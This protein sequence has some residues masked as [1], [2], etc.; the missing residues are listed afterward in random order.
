M[1]DAHEI[2]ERDLHAYVDGELAPAEVARVEAWLT[3]NPC[4]AAR[5]TAYRDQLQ[6]M[7]EA[8]DPVLSEAVP[9]RLRQAARPG[10]GD[11]MRVLVRLAAALALL[12]V[13]FGAGWLGRDA[14][15]GRGQP[16]VDLA[17][18]SL[19]AHRVYVVE[20]RH[21]VEVAANEEQHLVAWL[22]KRIGAPVRAPD[23]RQVG[24]SLVGGRLL[25]AAG[26]PAAQL[27]YETARGERVTIY[28]RA[29]G[30]DEETAFRYD[31]SGDLS[32]FYWLEK[33]LAYAIVAELPREDLLRVA[34]V[35]Y[36]QLDENPS[37]DW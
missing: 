18:E 23:L 16:Y 1:S 14:L 37:D 20:V 7:H 26:E 15:L 36:E 9:A 35:I 25:P 11:A 31:R 32:A 22:S 21:P 4:D 24:F 13:G 10:R 30:S 12:A 17:N 5:V 34:R 29:N 27:M 3:D 6:A 19:S 8:F 28:L 33:D 2:S